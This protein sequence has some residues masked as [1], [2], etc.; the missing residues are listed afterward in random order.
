MELPKRLGGLSLLLSLI[1]APPSPTPDP[2]DR[3]V[4]GRGESDVSLI[5]PFLRTCKD[6]HPYPP[7]LQGGTKASC[8]FHFYCFYT[9]LFFLQE[10]C[11]SSLFAH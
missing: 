2:M 10:W 7:E 11:F 5:S 1:G 3:A 4:N 9:F 6:R 8:A